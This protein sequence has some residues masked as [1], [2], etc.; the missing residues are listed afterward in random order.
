MTLRLTLRYLLAFILLLLVMMEMH[1]IVHISVGWM[2]C[3]CWGPRDFN[4]WELCD[5][6][7]KSE[8]LGWIATMA[9]PLFSFALMWLGMFWLSSVN[10]KKVA[11]GFSLIFS[12]IPFGRITTV[13]MGGGDEMVVVRHFMAAD[14]S[15][16]QMICG[17]TLIV[18][19]L[20]VPPIVKAFRII[21]NKRAWIYIVGFLTLPLL[22]LLVYTLIGLNTLLVSGFLASPWIMGTPVLITLHTSI[23]L[24]FLITFRRNLYSL[25]AL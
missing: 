6:C 12:N 22:F 1:E 3:G 14:F 11:V 13:M 16:I 20:G 25:K 5:A 24:I 9:G 7:E 21:Q 17:G 23:A 8:T 10:S 15:R 2:I 4:V 18:L 19:A